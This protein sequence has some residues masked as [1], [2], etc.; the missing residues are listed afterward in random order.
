M[1]TCSRIRAQGSP[2]QP[3][4]VD[5]IEIASSGVGDAGPTRAAVS[6]N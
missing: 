2:V 5:G 3:G 1:V 4:F 6:A